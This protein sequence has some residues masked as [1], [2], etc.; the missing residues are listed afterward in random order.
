MGQQDSQTAGVDVLHINGAALGAGH[1][2]FRD[3]Q[4]VPFLH[5][6]SGI[7]LA[8]LVDVILVSDYV[9]FDRMAAVAD[10]V[11]LDQFIFTFIMG[12]FIHRNVP[13]FLLRER[14]PFAAVQ[15]FPIIKAL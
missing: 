12:Q 3:K 2:L 6:R 4:D 1:A 9:G 5:G 13:V 7:S 15:Y 8:D 14:K 11:H 10:A